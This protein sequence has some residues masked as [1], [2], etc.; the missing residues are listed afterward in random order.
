MINLLP[1]E[2]RIKLRSSY[3]ERFVVVA[4]FAVAITLVPLILVVA[5]TSYIK[6]S[7]ID[8]INSEYSKMKDLRQTQGIEKLTDS[9]K[10]LNRIIGTFQGS[11]KESRPI[12]P[13]ITKIV[14]SRTS[15]IKITGVESII[16]EGAIS[17]RG[18]AKNRE[19]IINYGAILS[20]PKTGPCKSINVPVTTYTKKID[21]PFTILC[22]INYDAK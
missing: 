3:K 1:Y 17:I 7:N 9:I 5:A 22:A 11:I 19:A 4:L 6:Y 8:S 2:R 10:D 14:N 20:T 16:S 18:V 12:S 15:E 21:V 13:D